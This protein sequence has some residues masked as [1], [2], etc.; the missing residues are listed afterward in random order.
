MVNYK[1]ESESGQLLSNEDARNLRIKMALLKSSY[2]KQI[3]DSNKQIEALTDKLNE[4]DVGYQSGSEADLTIDSSLTT[5]DAAKNESQSRG[6]EEKEFIDNDIESIHEDIMELFKDGRDI[7]EVDDIYEHL[8]ETN[9]H[10][11]KQAMDEIVS[12]D[13]AEFNIGKTEL[14]LLAP[15]REYVL[16]MFLDTNS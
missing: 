8:F 5:F 13:W 14:R 3:D 16:N 12:F 2:E 9:K 1:K 6:I 10:I 4:V 11:I 15:G 7:I